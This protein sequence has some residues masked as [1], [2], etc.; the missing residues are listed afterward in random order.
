MNVDINDQLDLVL[1]RS[2]K[3]SPAQLWRAWTEPDLLKQWFAPKP[4]GMVKAAIDLVAGGEFN[5]VMCSPEKQAFPEKPGCV[6][7]GTGNGAWSGPMASGHG[8]GQT[9]SHL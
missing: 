3:A 1:E 4:Y 2:V 7:V 5:I 8:S 9:V 6:L